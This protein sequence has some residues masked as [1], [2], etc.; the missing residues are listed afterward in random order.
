MGFDY[1]TCFF[2]PYKAAYGSMPFHSAANPEIKQLYIDGYFCYAY[3]IGIV[4]NGL[5]IIKHIEFY[6]KAFFE[7]RPEITIK[8]KSDSPDEDKSVHDARLLSHTLQDFFTVHPLI[9]P[10]TFLGGVAFDSVRLYKELLSGDTF[11][12][13]LHFK[14]AYIPL[15]TRAHFENPD[16]SMDESG[17]PFCPKILLSQ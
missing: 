13:G 7:K 2:Y 6:N 8:K 11:G 16:Y 3:E 14:K 4:T 12:T 9:Q 17:I 10:D 1:S 15:N 5:G